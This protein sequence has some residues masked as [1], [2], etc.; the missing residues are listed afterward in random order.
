[1]DW[2][3]IASLALGL[4]IG[5][6]AVWAWYAFHARGA[7]DADKDEKE[8]IVHCSGYDVRFIL[9]TPATLRCEDCGLTMTKKSCQRHARER[10]LSNKKRFVEAPLTFVAAPPVTVR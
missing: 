2:Q 7:P 8:V 5:G 1:M 6:M 10:C 3:M 9:N 4:I